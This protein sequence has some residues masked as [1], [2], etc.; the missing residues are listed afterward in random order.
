MQGFKLYSLTIFLLILVAGSILT[1]KN[2]IT[3]SAEDF[4]CLKCH[5]GKDSL[6]KYV[7][8]GKIK[9]A[10]DLRNLVRQ[11]PKAGLHLTTSD[12]D[13][14]KAIRYLNLK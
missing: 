11:G 7:Q 13:L 1:F 10:S 12:E 2:T 3:T 4:K 5:K 9:S 6:E 8:E 14:E